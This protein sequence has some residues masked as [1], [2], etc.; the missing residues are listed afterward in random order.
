M[1]PV[2][3][4][5]ADARLAAAASHLG[6][7]HQPTAQHAMNRKTPTGRWA[8]VVRSSSS[9][10]QAMISETGVDDAVNPVPMLRQH[11]LA[12]D[13]GIDLLVD[14]RIQMLGASPSI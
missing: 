1:K 2:H 13:G 9:S 8:F 12:E 11:V 14:E 6:S 10:A 5:R 3:R 7:N 4:A